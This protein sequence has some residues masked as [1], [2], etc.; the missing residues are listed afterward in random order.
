[1][2]RLTGVLFILLVNFTLLLAFAAVSCTPIEDRIFAGTLENINER[3]DKAYI[4]A[5]HIAFTG[6]VVDANGMWL[7]NYLVILYLNGKEIGRDT[8][9]LQNYDESQVGPYNGLFKIRVRNDYQLSAEDTF[10]L[11]TGQTMTLANGEGFVGNTATIYKWFGDLR[12]GITVHINVPSKQI[13]Y[14]LYVSPTAVSALPS[15]IQHGVTVLN[16]AGGVV[17]YSSVDSLAPATASP[18]PEVN[19]QLSRASA[20]QLSWTYSLTGFF[21]NRWEVW[22]R[23]IVGR[24]PGMSWET[25][26]EQVLIHNPHLRQDGFVFYPGKTYVLPEVQQ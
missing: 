21:G 12:Q 24:V 20:G 18:V 9:R 7:D 16:E 3:I 25:F 8:T 10:V 4:T 5:S 23:Y 1:M 13:R 2:N 6:K 14:T 11:S 15:E 17:P 19:S 22:E 26:K